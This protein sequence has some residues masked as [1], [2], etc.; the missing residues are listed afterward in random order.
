[1]TNNTVLKRTL[2][3]LMAILMLITALCGFTATKASAATVVKTI[4]DENATAYIYASGA[5]YI[6][7]HRTFT[8]DDQL[9]EIDGVPLKEIIKFCN[10]GYVDSL[11]SHLNGNGII[12]DHCLAVTGKGP[13]GLYGGIL[14]VY[15]NT[16]DRYILTLISS[17]WMA[18]Y[19]YY[20]S[21]KPEIC[22]IEWNNL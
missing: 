15:D 3:S 18:H 6:E 10:G 20:N 7:L 14:R 19:V 16:N 1:M 11:Y 5:G 22:R 2:T 8:L 21:D 4:S 13:T 9:T 17:K 12:Y